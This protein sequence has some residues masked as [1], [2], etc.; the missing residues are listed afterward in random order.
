M[1]QKS[2]SVSH[3]GACNSEVICYDIYDHVL[4][5]LHNMIYMLTSKVLDITKGIQLHV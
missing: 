3:P 5:S 1:L 4:I 2:Y